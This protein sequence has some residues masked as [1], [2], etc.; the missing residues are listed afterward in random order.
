MFSTSVKEP[1]G[2]PSNDKNARLPKVSGSVNGQKPDV[3]S[4][5]TCVMCQDLVPVRGGS[6]NGSVNGFQNV[7]MMNDDADGSGNGNV[8]DLAVGSVNGV[9]IEMMMVNDVADLGVLVDTFICMHCKWEQSQSDMIERLVSIEKLGIRLSEESKERNGRLDKIDENNRRIEELVN[10]ITAQLLQESSRLNNRVDKQDE[11]L[12]VLDW[13]TRI[14]SEEATWPKITVV[15][16]Q[17]VEIVQSSNMPTNPV[18]KIIKTKFIRKAQ[19]AKK[20][21]MKNPV[22]LL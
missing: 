5:R 22:W 4:W 21:N 16:E 12:D 2:R 17:E 1:T 6:V 18:S 19:Q 3:I 7:L 20:R 11:K 14:N 8:N 9:Q 15:P 13:R 10:D